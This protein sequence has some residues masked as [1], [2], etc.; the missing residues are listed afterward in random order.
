MPCGGTAALVSVAEP[1][2]PPDRILAP[3]YF[4][5]SVGRSTGLCFAVA[6]G[7]LRISF[8]IQQQL[9]WNVGMA[10]DQARLGYRPRQPGSPAR[11][12]SAPR[13][14]AANP[15][16]RAFEHP[17]DRR[18]GDGMSGAGCSTVEQTRADI[19]A[20]YLQSD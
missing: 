16:L 15:I 20:R 12:L 5:M 13:A 4:V 11:C 18:I 14:T 6:G 19:Y 10:A 2:V 7:E 17:T 3:K 1:P 9:T 8:W